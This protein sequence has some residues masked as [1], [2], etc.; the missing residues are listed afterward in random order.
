MLI[1]IQAR[2]KDAKEPLGS[3]LK[4]AHLPGMLQHAQELQTEIMND[5]RPL[6][7]I[8][9]IT[10]DEALLAILGPSG[11]RM[12]AEDFDSNAESSEGHEESEFEA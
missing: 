7:N 5:N 3:G 6:A 12:G 11:I 10:D 9:L 1:Q 8:N 2:A 4:Q